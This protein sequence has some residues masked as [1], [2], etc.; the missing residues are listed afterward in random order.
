MKIFPCFKI[1]FKLQRLFTFSKQDNS[2]TFQD[3]HLTYKDG[4]D[5]QIKV[6]N[7]PWRSLALANQMGA[8]QLQQHASDLNQYKRIEKL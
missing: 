8:Q 4:L 5:S 7:L 2:T 6:F 3:S 1:D